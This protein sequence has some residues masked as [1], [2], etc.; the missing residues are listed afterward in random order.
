MDKGSKRS[1]SVAMPSPSQA[2]GGRDWRVDTLRGYALV[3]MT[4]DHLPNQPLKRFTEYLLGYAS[5][6]DAFVFLSGLVSGWVYLKVLDQ[7]GMPALNNRA[8]R[9]ARDIYVVHLSLL[10]LTIAGAVLFNH[11]TFRAQHPAQAFVA[12]ALL[13]YQPSLSD[14]LPMYCIFL[15]FV[16]LV[17]SQLVKGSIRLVIAISVALW[18]LSQ[19]GIGDASQLVP[20]IYL[21]TFNLLAWQVYFVAGLCFAFHTRRTENAI[22]RSRGL[23][24]FCAIAATLLFVDR[25]LHVLAGL[26]PL[27]KFS[28]GPDHNPVRFFDAACLGYVIWSVPRTIDEKLKRVQACRFLNSLG[29]H[30]LQVYAFSLFATFVLLGLGNRWS[31]LP[32]WTRILLVLFVVLS[33]ALPARVHE[34][35]RQRRPRVKPPLFDLLPASQAATAIPE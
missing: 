27:L 23:L 34:Y 28:G 6:P 22:P 26:K 9:R 11:G 24:A 19:F 25:H 12:G 10:V 30:S 2:R 15:L 17:L 3:M 16:P 14:I 31:S 5:A 21:G 4:V 8:L 13:I 7:R 18:M 33:L 32:E 29:R 20:W 35:L 1:Q